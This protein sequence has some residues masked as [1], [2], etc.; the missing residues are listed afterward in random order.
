MYTWFKL[1][2]FRDHIRWCQFPTLALFYCYHNEEFTRCRWCLHQIVI[3]RLSFLSF[4]WLLLTYKS[5]KA[6]VTTVTQKSSLKKWAH[7]LTL[8]ME[9]LHSN[10]FQNFGLQIQ[11]LLLLLCWNGNPSQSTL[12]IANSNQTLIDQSIYLFKCIDLLESISFFFKHVVIIL[13]PRSTF[14]LQA[15]VAVWMPDLLCPNQPRQQ[16]PSPNDDV[17]LSWIA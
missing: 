8:A 2:R 14:L 17:Q 10:Q 3:T 6:H 11:N 16:C 4:Q 12:N 7:N 13:I 5:L 1:S 9:D 15:F